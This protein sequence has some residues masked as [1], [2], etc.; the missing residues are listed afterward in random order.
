MIQSQLFRCIGILRH[1]FHVFACSSASPLSWT[2]KLI[3]V[4]YSR[5]NWRSR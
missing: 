4:A 5:V 3:L 2:W 1:H